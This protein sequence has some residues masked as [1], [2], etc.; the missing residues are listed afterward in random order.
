MNNNIEVNIYILIDII[1]K[2][3]M[4]INYFD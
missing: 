3:I 2:F 4:I 1:L